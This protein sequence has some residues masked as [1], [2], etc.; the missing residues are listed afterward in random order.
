MNYFTG[1]ILNYLTKQYRSY[2]EEHDE[3]FV[4]R[5]IVID[6]VIRNRTQQIWITLTCLL[7]FGVSRGSW[8]KQFTHVANRYAQRDGEIVVSIYSNWLTWFA[9]HYH[10][11]LVFD[12]ADLDWIDI[13]AIIFKSEFL[14]FGECPE[15]D[16]SYVMVKPANTQVVTHEGWTCYRFTTP[17]KELS[18]LQ[19]NLLSGYPLYHQVPSVICTHHK[20]SVKVDIDCFDTISHLVW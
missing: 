18:V 5:S 13:I 9:C 3:L 7:V 6:H 1:I 10:I 19:Q 4:D 8:S 2:S 20:I 11:C 17:F 14:N 15:V 12:S 16:C